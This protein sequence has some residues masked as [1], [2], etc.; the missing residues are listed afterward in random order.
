[1][2]QSF[3]NLMLGAVPVL[4]LALSSCDGSSSTASNTIG[5][6]RPILLSTQYGRLVDIYAY[7]RINEQRGDRRDRFNRQPVLIETDVVINPNIE[8]QS[9]FDASGEEVPTADYEFMP[10]DIDTGHEELLILWD[11]RGSEAAN[12]QDALSRAQQGRPELAAAYRGQNTAS[13]PIPVVPRDAAIVLEFSGQI[14]VEENFFALNPSA[15]QLLEFKGDPDIVSPIDAFRTIPTRVIPKGA[16]IVMDT[17]I[18]GGEAVAGQLSRGMPAS[19]DNVTANIRLAV[20][21]RGS[22]SR[23]FYVR[24]DDVE[25]LNGVDSFG[26]PSVIRDFRSGNASDGLAGKLRDLMP[27]MIVGNIPMG[28]TDIDSEGVITLNKRDHFVQVRGTYPFVR[29][30]LNDD[31]GFPLGPASSPTVQALAIG[32]FLTQTVRVFVNGVQEDIEVRAEILWNL[33]I[34]TVRDDPAFPGLGLAGD[35]SIGDTLPQVRVIVGN[36]RGQDSQGNPVGFVADPSPLG[37]DC[38]LR[39]FYYE[40]VAYGSGGSSVSDRTNRLDFLQIQPEPIQTATG[41]LVAANASISLEFSE[42]MD[43]ES[44]DPTSNYLLSLPSLPGQ[45]PG[46][47]TFAD[48]ISDAKL[49][50]AGVVPSRLSDQSGDG[51]VLQLQPPRGFFHVQSVSETYWFHMLLDSRGLTDLAGNQVQ[52]YGDVGSDLRHWSLPFNLDP[53]SDHNLVGWHVYRFEDIDEDGTPPGSVDIFGQY[54]I[55]DGRLVAAQTVRFS[56]TADTFNLAPISRIDR[57]ECWDRDSAAQIPFPGAQPYATGGGPL[58]GQLYLQPQMLDTVG[59]PNVPPVFLPPNSPQPVGYVIEPHQ[60]RGSRMMQRYIEDD[61]DLSYRLP[62][63]MAIDI[64]QL[65][66]SPFN[67]QEILFDV[68]DRY[69]M[70]LSH[71]ARRADMHYFLAQNAEEELECLLACPTVDSGL[72]TTFLDNILPGTEQVPVFEDRVYQI[73]PN[74][75]FL[76]TNNFKYISYPSFDR[77]YTWRDSRHV[78]VDEAGNVIGLGGA[79]NPAAPEPNNDWTANI[80]SPWVQSD[81]PEE[82]T[83]AGGTTWV[84]DDGDFRGDRRLD[85]DPIALPL[86]VDFK[87]FPDGASNGLAAGTNGFQMAMVSAPTNFALGAVGGYYSLINMLGCGPRPFWP[88]TRIHSTGGLEPTTSEPVLINPA[89]EQVAQGGWIK[90]AGAIVITNQGIAGDG[91]LG[92]FRAPGGDAMINWAQ[93]DFVRKVSMMTFGFI[94]TQQPNRSASSVGVPDFADPVIAAEFGTVAVQ[95]LITMLDPPQNQQPA[96]TS[97]VVE[98]RG[99]QAIGEGGDPGIYDPNT[100]DDPET[101]GNLYNPNYSCEA[102][103]YSQPNSGAGFDQARVQATELSAY[104]T[105]DRLDELRRPTTNLL[106]R[107]LNMRLIMTNN[108]D[109][110]PALSPSLRSMSVI[111]S[112]VSSQ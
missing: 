88:I 87:M 63:D 105:E 70:S 52:V 111:Y 18:L 28:I 95:D 44:I 53:D 82:F 50:T 68:F 71:T 27:P 100:D 5:D 93:A 59:P 96:G 73:N 84:M 80:D 35:G 13:Q 4:L 41:P 22:V 34:G 110:S 51:T 92:I 12:F 98:F 74:N 67:N 8:T 6:D 25:Q 47:E 89:T 83:L 104:V 101:R 64:E 37:Q 14:Q 112:M 29:G 66:W 62:N 39:T 97:V 31:T 81:A 108:V 78:T 72:S 61:F 58:T 43:F 79:A 16:Q 102:Y 56:R 48:L 46:G 75:A 23:L 42:P 54:R 2:K 30:A 17:T 26:R 55:L 107:Y 76:S 77:S 21:D 99:S 9:L 65:Y 20:P 32:D 90:D 38:A 36:V 60:P 15:L 3:R 94:D 49:A 109:V 1:M 19:T 69:S 11:N 106:P 91:Q 7:Q 85:H 45:A 57:G 40:D 103:R 10:F 33:E 86:L 24:A